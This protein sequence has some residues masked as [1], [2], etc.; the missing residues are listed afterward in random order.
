MDQIWR[1][2]IEMQAFHILAYVVLGAIQFWAIKNLQIGYG[3]A[4]GLSTIGW[5]TWSWIFA[6]LFQFWVAF[7]WRMELHGGWVS[8]TFGKAGFVIHQVGYGVLG[9]TRF[10]ML[11]PI[12]ISTR[13]TLPLPPTLSIAIIVISTP[14][15]IWALYSATVYFGF[16]RAAGADHFRPEFRQKGFEKKGMYK[17]V[18][19]VMYSVALFGLYHAGLLWLSSLGL[20]VTACHHLFVWTHYF[21]TEKPDM[22]EIYG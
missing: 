6:G 17:Y 9:L 18:P 20:I 16:A 8:R 11:I 14:P 10:V 22:K 12:C 13:A 21:C 5:V 2:R 4:W 7:F 19:N 15:I 3:Q 1:K